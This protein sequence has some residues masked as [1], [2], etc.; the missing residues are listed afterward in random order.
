M[1]EELKERGKFVNFFEEEFNVIEIP[2]VSSVD[3]LI[4]MIKSEKIDAIAIDYKLKDHKS[5][6]TENG[7]FFFKQL[8][9]RLP[10]YPSFVL[11]Q[12]SEKAKK[13]SKLI[14]SRFIIDKKILHSQIIKETDDFKFEVL[15]EI[16]TYRNL[17][18][19]KVKRLKVLETNRLANDLDANLENEYIRLNNEI[20]LSVTGHETLPMKYFSLETSKKLDDIISKTDELIKKISKK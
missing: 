19:D 14:K 3:E 2:F 10:D 9:S 11:T 18:D 20:A 13:E 15:Q 8:I 7:D 6:F 16:E 5:K 17:F 4:E 1:D 12:D